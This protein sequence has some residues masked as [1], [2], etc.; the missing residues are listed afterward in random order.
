MPAGVLGADP[1]ELKR[2]A[3]SS[4]TLEKS[5]ATW[6]VR[7]LIQ[8]LN[9][10]SGRSWASCS[11]QACPQGLAGAGVVDIVAGR[12]RVPRSLRCFV[13]RGTVK[14]ADFSLSKTYPQFAA[15]RVARPRALPVHPLGFAGFPEG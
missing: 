15:G 8:V 12:F 14:A 3:T 13:D 4:V 11:V 6:A 7:G 10:C 2:L 9:C 1:V 5:G